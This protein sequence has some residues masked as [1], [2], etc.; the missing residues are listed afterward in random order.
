MV[1][2]LRKDV[3]R[4]TVNGIPFFAGERYIASFNAV[5]QTTDIHRPDDRS[6]VQGDEEAMRWQS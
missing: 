3:A 1:M 2:G 4:R 6:H 5:L